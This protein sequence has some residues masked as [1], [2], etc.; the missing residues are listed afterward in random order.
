M[1]EIQE[2]IPAGAP[3]GTDAAP[4]RIDPKLHQILYKSPTRAKLEPMPEEV[5]PEPVY[6]QNPIRWR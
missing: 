5:L 2:N 4:F 6:P 3:L 1:A